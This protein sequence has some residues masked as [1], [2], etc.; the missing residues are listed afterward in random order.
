MKNKDK[1]PKLVWVR[2]L[3]PG[4]L[5]ERLHK[6]EQQNNPLKEQKS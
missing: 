2:K 3:K 1:S 5:K 4:K 6:G